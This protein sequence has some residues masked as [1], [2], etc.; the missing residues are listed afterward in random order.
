MPSRQGRGCVI[1]RLL[2]GD[3][4]QGCRGNHCKLLTGAVNQT[5]ISGQI[6]K[7]VQWFLTILHELGRSQLFPMAQR[8]PCPRF[9]NSSFVFGEGQKWIFEA[10]QAFYLDSVPFRR[11]SVAILG[12]CCWEHLQGAYSQCLRIVSKHKM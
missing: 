10:G 6:L 3:T 4:T 1:K 11:V 7:L 12:R 5:P 2:I 8:S 9:G